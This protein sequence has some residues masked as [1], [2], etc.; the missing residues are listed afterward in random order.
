[1]REVTRISLLKRFYQKNP[2]FEGW[3][4]LKFNKLGLALSMAMKFNGRE[5]KK[6]HLKVREFCGQILTFVEVTAEKLV[7]GHSF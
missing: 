3:P 6:L 5:T 7:G 1:M 2:F 4:W